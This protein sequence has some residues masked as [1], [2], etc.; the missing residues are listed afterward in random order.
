MRSIEMLIIYFIKVGLTIL[1]V[2]SCIIQNYNGNE[3][4]YRLRKLQE[5][6][7]S[8][9]GKAFEA[10]NRSEAP[11][12]CPQ[13]TPIVKEATL[14]QEEEKLEEESTGIFY[15]KIPK[16]SSSILARITTRV[17]GREAKRQGFKTDINDPT[18]C[19]LHN[20]MI[21]FYAYQLNVSKRDKMKSFLWSMIRQPE[22]RGN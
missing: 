21:H 14:V 7:T 18:T 17:A 16:T 4:H 15:I 20:P 11:F 13:E 9:S 5:E 19:K 22:D 12:P 8:Q 1:L 10:W 3:D 2:S 6:I